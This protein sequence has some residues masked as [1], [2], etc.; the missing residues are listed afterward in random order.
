MFSFQIMH[1][2][3]IKELNDLLN[4][5]LEAAIAYI[6]SN[7]RVLE[8]IDFEYLAKHGLSKK[9]PA[10]LQ[11]EKVRNLITSE[12]EFIIL[13]FLCN[14]ALTM[15]LL[16]DKR[17]LKL[18][19]P[20]LK[21]APLDFTIMRYLVTS[22]GINVQNKSLSRSLDALDLH[23]PVQITYKKQWPAMDFEQRGYFSAEMEVLKTFPTLKNY[24]EQMMYGPSGY[25][26]R[27]ADFKSDFVTFASSPNEVPGLAAAFAYQLY[28]IRLKL[29]KKGVLTATDVFPILECGA[30]LGKLCYHI[31]TTIKK[32]GEKEASWAAFFASIHYTSVE[33][34]KT[35]HLQQQ[36]NTQEFKEK[37]TLI[38]GDARQLQKYLTGKKIA[39]A[40]SN[41][42]IDELAPHVVK[43]NE[44]WRLKV[45][46]TIPLIT[47][48]NL[49]KAISDRK[50][51]EAIEKESQ[52]NKRLL[53]LI[54]SDFKENRIV[55][56]EKTF[57]ELHHLLVQKGQSPLPFLF[58]KIAKIDARRIP[59]IDD[60]LKRNPDFYLR[61]HPNFTRF[62]QIGSEKYLNNLHPLL[63]S[64]G[65]VIT[66]DYGETYDALR[67]EVFKTHSKS[68]LG[69]DIFVDPSDKDITFDVNMTTLADTPGY[70][71]VFFGKQ[72][73][74]RIDTFPKEVLS[75]QHKKAFVESSKARAFKV[76][77]QSKHERLDEKKVIEHKTDPMRFHGESA[78]VSEAEINKKYRGT[79]FDIANYP[80]K[81]LYAEAKTLCANNPKFDS[82][83]NAI[84]EKQ[85]SVAL[86]K[87]ASIGSLR[88]TTLLLNYRAAIYFDVN[89]R[90]SNGNTALDWIKQA[91]V[92]T[93]IR[94]L[95]IKQ[96]IKHGATEEHKLDKTVKLK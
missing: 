50:K 36:Q 59:E 48:E 11:F 20:V 49:L 82:Y 13:C 44:D 54:L 62:I 89:E 73:Q 68:T 35:L 63:V 17:I 60:F 72:E 42:F 15:Q 83:L 2:N 6:K 57:L 84:K 40:I 92:K 52:H 56:S 18:A 19:M 53:S 32:M 3:T 79:L 12:S 43:L 66:I 69:D 71:T 91:K 47:K 87:A 22:Y 51:I 24:V 64:G 25:Y 31:L 10:L 34:S 23:L 78:P 4:N 80:H 46:Q 61:M 26:T 27:K 75:D 38:H 95:I 14:P 39:A 9:V 76:I 88:L 7:S 1:I 37:V 65:E 58:G 96:L 55:L 70:Q 16:D 90:S 29:L 41:E 93:A 94:S 45:W 85:Y 30:G 33:I 81:I 28:H 8:L 86:R 77:V 67:N 21:L 5:N 74:L